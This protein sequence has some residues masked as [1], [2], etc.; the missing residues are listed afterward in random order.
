MAL[1]LGENKTK[2]SGGSSSGPRYLVPADQYPA[3]VVEIIDV[4]LHPKLNYKTKEIEGQQYKVRI[5]YELL[6]AF[7]PDEEGND[8]LD[9][10]VFVTEEINIS[11]ALG[12]AD[13]AQQPWYSNCG[14]VKRARA[15]LGNPNAV[16]GDLA[17]LLGKACSVLVVHEPN[18]RDPNI[19]YA[20][21]G[22]VASDPFKIMKQEAPPL[23]NEP[24][25]LDLS[26]P[27]IDVY[28]SQ[29]QF[30][31]DKILNNLEFSGSKLE[32]LLEGNEYFVGGGEEH[33][34][35]EPDGGR[36]VE[37][38]AGDGSNEDPWDD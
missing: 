16:V 28:N 22:D 32:A 25:M 20:K 13:A 21:V 29:P 35:N 12:Y 26:D 37:Q 9:K 8:Q 36:E 31:K 34:E 30:I 24:K 11:P 17:E 15:I 27:D 4:G 33:S 5:T 2:S 38:M 1:K 7:V 23:V 6:T 18:K 10:P 14:I 3:R 19:V